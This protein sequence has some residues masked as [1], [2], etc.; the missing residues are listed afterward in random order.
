MNRRLL[1]A[2]TALAALLAGGAA[3]LARRRPAAPP[4]E[5][6]AVPFL[7]QVAGAAKLLRYADESSPLR[8]LRW[9]P[10][11]PGGLHAVQ[12]L[13]QTDRQR[14]ALFENG[15]FVGLWLIPRPEGVGEG[16]FR[17][18]EL[19]AAAAGPE[20]LILLYRAA[21]GS[22]GEPSLLLALDRRDGTV[23]W[24]R[25]TG[26]RSITFQPGAEGPVALWCFGPEAP[27]QRVDLRTGQTGSPL[28]LP[29][30]VQGPAQILAT[31]NGSLLIAHGR[32]LAIRRAPETWVHHPL[33]ADESAIPALPSAGRLAAGP[34]GAWWQPRPDRIVPVMA[35]GSLGE[36]LQLALP[37][38]WDGD[39][40]RLRLLG[41]D[42]DGHLWFDLAAAPGIAPPA[43]Q[44]EGWEEAGTPSPETPATALVSDVSRVYRFDALHRRFGQ[45]RIDHAW[46]ALQIS[47]A[48]P[49]SFAGLAPAGGAW[50]HPQADGGL[51]WI[52]LA[53]LPLVAVEA[54]PK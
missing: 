27:P 41:V 6:E 20:V 48:A 28:E 31:R 3:Y 25:R 38:P 43:P 32:G 39:A 33:P 53:R 44:Q 24:T 18:A 47:A 13:T 2:V 21:E 12:I 52:P 5:T 11:G 17:L 50:A 7:S 1:I 45:C 10:P 19:D 8:A 23:R 15:S 35:D 29:P 30:D 46:K 26:G 49:G 22:R 36:A 42:P 9:L 37:E 14:V 51:L 34:K 16:F 4:Q 54:Q 40:Q